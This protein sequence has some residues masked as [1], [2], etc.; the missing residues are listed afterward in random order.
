[1]FYKFEQRSIGKLSRVAHGNVH[2]IDF[3][4]DNVGCPSPVGFSVGAFLRRG[5]TS[6]EGV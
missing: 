2:K 3:D 5:D 1:M 4:P 6:I